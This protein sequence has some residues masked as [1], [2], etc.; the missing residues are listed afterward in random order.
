MMWICSIDRMLRRSR[1]RFFI[2]MVSIAIDEPHQGG[3][4]HYWP[5]SEFKFVHQC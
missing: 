4:A 3:E 5:G 1:M 2:F